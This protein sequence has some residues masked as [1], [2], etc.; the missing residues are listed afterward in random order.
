MATVREFEVTGAVHHA[1][2]AASKLGVN[3]VS[4]QIR[5]YASWHDLRVVIRETSPS[6]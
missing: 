5:A 6:P 2:R 1:H 4:I 3:L